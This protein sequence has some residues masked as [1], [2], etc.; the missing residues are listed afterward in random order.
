MLP[1]DNP[2]KPDWRLDFII[3]G[4]SAEQATKLLSIVLAVADM[5]HT[6]VHGRWTEVSSDSRNG[7]FQN[8]AAA[9]KTYAAPQKE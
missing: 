1:K 3:E 2:K 7:Y 9:Q 6:S 8:T 4:V 5:L